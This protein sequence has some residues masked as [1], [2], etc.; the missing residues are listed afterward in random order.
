MVLMSGFRFR[1]NLSFGV[2]ASDTSDLP[3]VVYWLELFREGAE[4]GATM[5]MKRPSSAEF[6]HTLPR[7]M[8]SHQ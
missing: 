4:V 5:M 3:M 7:S 2:R 1:I 8:G 6:Q